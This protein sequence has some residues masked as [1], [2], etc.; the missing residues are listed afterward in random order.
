[1]A[2]IFEWVHFDPF[3]G[4]CKLGHLSHHN[5]CIEATHNLQFATDNLQFLNRQ[6]DDKFRPPGDIVLNADN[7]VVVSDDRA[8]NGQP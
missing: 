4:I 8:D 5:K 3:W 7:A 1:M 6:L 2:S